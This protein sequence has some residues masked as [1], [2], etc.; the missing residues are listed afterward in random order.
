R[1]PANKSLTFQVERWDGGVLNGTIELDALAVEVRGQSWK[2][3]LRDIVRLETPSPELTETSRREISSLIEQ[4]G[5]PEWRIREEATRE[6]GAF[7]YL[8]GPLLRS[9]LHE[10]ED[11]EVT[12]RIERI[13]A[14][15][16]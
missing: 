10:S 9:K 1:S 3:P 13:L 2:I 16:N 4:L 15:L 5:A 7:G 6:L 11:P 12:R 8:A 14:E